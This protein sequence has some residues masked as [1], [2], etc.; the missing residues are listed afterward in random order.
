MP[1]KKTILCPVFLI[2]PGDTARGTSLRRAV[3]CPAG[4]LLNP[5]PRQEP[6]EA[7]PHVTPTGP[8]THSH[9]AGGMEK[10]IEG[11]GPRACN[12]PAALTPAST[13]R[14]G[15]QRTISLS[16]NSNVSISPMMDRDQSGGTL[17]L[18]RLL[19]F[20]ILKSHFCCTIL[21]I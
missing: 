3:A 10:G 20:E 4:I 2:P 13:D 18:T 9:V 15:E 5:S 8:H 7:P 12:T 1:T 17:D 21:T 6:R 19:N 16:T 11:S 14:S